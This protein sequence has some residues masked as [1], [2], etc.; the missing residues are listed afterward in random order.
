MSEW[1]AIDLHMHTVVGT[2]GNGKKD[3]VKNFSYLNYI[4][5]IQQFDLKLTAITNHNYIDIKNYI[6]CKYLSKQLDSNVLFG[7]ELDTDRADGKNYHLLMIFNEPIT[8]CIKISEN[9]NKKTEVKKTQNKVRYS[10]DEIITFIENYDVA[11]VPHGDKDKGLLQRP[12]YE[13][14]VDALKKV[15]EGF[16]RVFDSPSNWKLAEI[17]KIIESEKIYE[18]IDDFGGVLFSDNRDWINYSANSRKFYM[19]AEPTFNGFVHSITNPV[20]R[21][22]IKDNIPFT[23]NYIKRIEINADNEN[24]RINNCCIELKSGYNCIIGKS[25]SGKSLLLHIIKSY[26][27]DDENNVNYKFVANNSIKIY[28]ENNELLEKNSI[29]M[30]IGES[31]F[32]QIVNSSD[33][34]NQEDMY[35]VIK[36]LQSNFK[37]KKKFNKFVE[38]YKDIIL[39][40]VTNKQ[41][42]EELKKGLKSK[43]VT[44]KSDTVELNKLS[45]INMFNLNI[46]QEEKFDYNT[47]EIEIFNDFDNKYNELYKIIDLLKTSEKRKIIEKLEEVKKLFKEEL[48]LVNK[49]MA[50]INYKNAKIKIISKALG[51]INSSISK[52]AKRKQELL[53][54]RMTNIGQ[55]IS[56]FKQYYLLKKKLHFYD[57][58]IDVNKINSEEILFEEEKITIDELIDVSEVK[59]L[60]IKNNNIFYTRGIQ[61]Q[62]ISKEYDMRSK[63]EAKIVIDK[64]YELNKLTKQDISKMFSEINLQV[65]VYFN[66]QNVKELNPGTISKTYIELYFKTQLANDSNTVILY[67]QIENDVDKEFIATTIVESIRKAKKKAQV[68]IVTHDPIVAVNADPI[69]YIEAIKDSNNKI[70][71]R[72]FVPESILSDE[73]KTIARNV[74]GSIKVIK[75][76]YEIYRGEKYYVD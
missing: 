29:N 35:E 21:F 75:E 48:L 20:D 9:I 8:R 14:I 19:N 34:K 2:T 63:D 51:I 55:I 10:S 1:N 37:P 76:R 56:N 62:L 4:K 25:G 71:Y 66:G 12:T 13:E 31:I 53:E 52:N 64:Y 58:S 49:E 43:I 36:L 28:N 74:D 33:S 47:S 6:L 38:E 65:N 54:S 11:I 44:F 40:Y 68:I 30:G 69:N 15:R 23:S 17:K 70:T 45:D 26:L 41:I 60:N 3:E 16:I 27:T 72:N 22:S 61:Q 57:L 73:L 18:N 39:Q 59:N 50:L 32:L 46:Q 7:V 67:D 42:F 5:V 24:S